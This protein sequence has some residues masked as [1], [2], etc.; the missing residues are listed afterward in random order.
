MKFDLHTHS[1]FSDGSLSPEE[2]VAYA[3]ERQIDYL[4]LTDHDTVAGIE[5]AEQSTELSSVNLISGVEIS[6]L[7]DF[8][9][10]HIVGLNIDAKNSALQ[11]ALSQQINKRWQ[12]AEN[13]S[14]KLEKLGCN[15]VF[16][17]LQKNVKNVAT[18]THIAKTLVDMGYAKDMNQ[19]FKI[20]LGKKGRI[21][22]PKEW[23]PMEEAIGLIKQAGGIAVLAH[24]TR[25]PLS[26]RKLS[27]LI[28]QFKLEQGDG[29]EMA[30]PSLTKDKIEWLELHRNKNNLLASSGSDFHYPDLNWRD[31]GRFPILH[32]S[33][34]HVNSLLN[35]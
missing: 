8:G 15:G 35:I 6:A 29:I 20:Y 9:E 18:R 14:E 16:E 3:A 25:Y 21:K 22:V 19:V 5:R 30:Y 28:E 17:Q 2:M 33:I 34:P 1:Y 24:P 13:I 32:E 11:T 31:M 12:R 27:L 4:A 10:I 7:T 23:M 26:N